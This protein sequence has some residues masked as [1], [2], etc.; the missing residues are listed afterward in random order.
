M[1]KGRQYRIADPEYG[2][3][4]PRC[5]GPKFKRSAMCWACYTDARRR[6]EYPLPPVPERRPPT[7]LET[8]CACP[9]CRRVWPKP[10][11]PSCRLYK[12][13][14]RPQPQSHPWRRYWH[15]DAA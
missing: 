12:G 15:K 2:T 11:E 5:A 13:R 9:F 3:V 10:H 14:G 6:H 8:F 4:C 7:P 1:A